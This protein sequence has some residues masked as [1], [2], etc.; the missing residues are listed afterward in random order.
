[1]TEER[2]VPLAAFRKF[3]D[4][5]QHGFCRPPGRPFAVILKSDLLDGLA[6]RVVAP[7]IPAGQVKRV[8]RGLN[9]AVSLPEGSSC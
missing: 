1:M 9:P 5:G 2:G 8:L 7:L 4:C 3:W 6:I